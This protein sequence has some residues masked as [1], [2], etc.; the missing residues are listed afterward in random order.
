MPRP[1]IFALRPTREEGAIGID[2][3][4]G[5]VRTDRQR[6]EHLLEI[7]KTQATDDDACERSVRVRQPPAQ[8]QYRL[9]GRLRDHRAADVQFR[10][11]ALPE[12]LEIVPVGAARRFGI[13][14]ARVEADVSGLVEHE[15]AVELPGGRRAIEQQQLAQLGRHLP[16]LGAADIV[17]DGLEGQIEALDVEENVEL[18]RGD[19]A[20]RRIACAVPGGAACIDEERGTDRGKAHGDEKQSP[21]QTVGGAPRC[22][23]AVLVVQFRRLHFQ[24]P[25]RVLYR[26]FRFGWR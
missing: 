11:V 18:E 23:L 2:E 16:D 10:R 6:P 22:E 19:E 13:R 1:K 15:N 20:R 24:N 25:V 7:G 9:A 8:R 17:D 3:R 26:S 21:D 14:H 5:V 4:D 12:K